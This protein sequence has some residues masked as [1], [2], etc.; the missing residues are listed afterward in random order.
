M[1]G[2]DR[3][4]PKAADYTTVLTKIKSLNPDLLY[5]GG[6]AQA[7]VKLVKQSYDIVPKMLKAGGDGM[8]RPVVLSGAGF[9]A[10]DGWYATVASPHMM[11]AKELEP[12]V[13]RFSAK[14]D[15][16]RLTIRLPLT[17]LRGGAGRDP[18][19]G[20]DRQ[21]GHAGCGAGCDPGNEAEDAAG[22]R[23]I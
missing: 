6:D 9:P 4:D 17:M 10:A 19:G 1:L 23:F 18:S 20:E 13:K 11:D 2:H 21:A 16:Q 7:G 3:L 14:F 12:W 8:V 5:Y 22:G 15:T